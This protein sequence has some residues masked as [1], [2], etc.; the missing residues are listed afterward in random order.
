[1]EIIRDTRPTTDLSVDFRRLLA[2]YLA[3]MT[4]TITIK[5][6]PKNEGDDMLHFKDGPEQ[7]RCY[8]GYVAGVFTMLFAFLAR[9]LVIG[10]LIG[11]AGAMLVVMIARVGID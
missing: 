7:L 1:M 5:K 11:F 9:S 6:E 4:F 3:A 8:A 2:I 10:S